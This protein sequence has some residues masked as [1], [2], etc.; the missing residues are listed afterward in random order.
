MTKPT[1]QKGDHLLDRYLIT[2]ILHQSEDSTLYQA[3]SD[4]IEPILYAIKESHLNPA[5]GLT[6]DQAKKEFHR[7]AKLFEA[8]EHPAISRTFDHFSE[9]DRVFLICEF[10]EGH[11]LEKLL[12]ER[13]GPFPIRDVVRWGITLASA[14]EYLHTLA[15]DPIIFRDLK[16]A[17]V[18]LD[19]ER[20]A[21]LVDLGI[22][23]IFPQGITLDPLG[24][25]GY[26]APEQ[27]NGIVTPTVDIYALGATLHHL[28]TAIDPRFEEPF[29]FED[30]PIRDA[31]PAVS[32]ELEGMI[33]KAAAYD[34]EKRYQ[35]A[36]EFRQALITI[37]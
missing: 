31:N 25:D 17:N 5:E 29:S 15:P 36:K 32:P 23:G 12:M 1:H 10:I 20:E 27:Y 4:S 9:D 6:L 35:T 3:V 22:A 26:A 21:H 19:S 24:T 28:L 14:L 7:R 2:R 18:V 16:P 30:R 8:L 33:L 13:E 37:L 11:D 34:P